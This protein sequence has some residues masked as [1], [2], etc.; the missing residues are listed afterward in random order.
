MSKKTFLASLDQLYSILDFVEQH[1][2]ERGF[3]PDVTQK[4][5]IATE[6]VVVNI[7]RYSSAKRTD[8]ECLTCEEKPGL[9]ILI[10]DDGIPYDLGPLLRQYKVK[11]N[12]PSNGG[13]G[14]FGIFL[15]VHLMDEV[16]Y[17]REEGVNRLLLIKYLS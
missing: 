3:R 15:Y 5:L 14:G 1:C 2:E 4:V 13:V 9:K 7:F 17:Q 8:I 16:Q 12:P 11:D 10:E 6:E